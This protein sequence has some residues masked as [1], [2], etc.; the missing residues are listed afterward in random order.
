[1]KQIWRRELS[2]LLIAAMSVLLL[3]GCETENAPSNSGIGL[4]ELFSTAPWFPKEQLVYEG[5]TEPE[6]EPRVK[7]EDFDWKN[8]KEPE[9]LPNTKDPEALD[10]PLPTEEELKKQYY[11][12]DLYDDF[13]TPLL[14]EQPF[15]LLDVVATAA[16]KSPYIEGIP[17]EILERAKAWYDVNLKN[18]DWRQIDLYKE[19][20]AYDSALFKRANEAIKAYYWRNGGDEKQGWLGK[21]SRPYLSDEQVEIIISGTQEEIDRAFVSDFSIMV[22]DTIYT[23]KMLLESSVEELK[24]AGITRAMMEDKYVNEWTGYF[25]DGYLRW[26]LKEKLM[27]M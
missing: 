19:L 17:E 8:D 11:E 10:G 4:S 25:G 18:K 20:A 5:L 21:Y 6:P 24:A 22:G 15:S 16:W 27:Q 12:I 14:Y 26:D 13:H 2:Y 1:M 3:A 7:P 23:P 9:P